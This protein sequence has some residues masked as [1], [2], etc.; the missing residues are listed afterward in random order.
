[1]PAGRPPIYK[2][3]DEMLPKLQ[4]WEES[5]KN[6]EKPTITGLC[7]SLDFESK[8]TLYAYK[9]KEGFSYPIKKA[10]L[11]VENGYEKALRE[12]NSTGPIFALKNM[13]WTDKHV[14]D[15][16]SSDGTMSPKIEIVRP[17]EGK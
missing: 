2:S 13:G 3:I 1:M 12:N 6:G 5:I 4:E 17:D 11:I 10:I 9:E 15:M 7:L 8:D 16:Q 14:H